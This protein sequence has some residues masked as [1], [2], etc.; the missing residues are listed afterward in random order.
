MGR[1]RTETNVP[2]RSLQSSNKR[3]KKQCFAIAKERVRAV[4]GAQH[5]EYESSTDAVLP[6]ALA[7]SDAP[8]PERLVAFV[9]ARAVSESSFCSCASA[10]TAQHTSNLGLLTT[11]H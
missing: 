3:T 11:V 10:N 4:R 9:R 2:S 8:A 5:E 1:E 6:T 7:A